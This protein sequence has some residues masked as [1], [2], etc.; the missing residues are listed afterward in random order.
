MKWFENSTL[1]IIHRITQGHPE[2]SYQI[3]IKAYIIAAA[4]KPN[5]F[6]TEVI[7]AATIKFHLQ[8]KLLHCNRNNCKCNYLDCRCKIA[9]AT[10]KTL[11]T[12][13]KIFKSI[14]TI[15]ILLATEVIATAI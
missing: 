14:A 12:V 2:S 11:N 1:Q 13:A 3:N 10:A 7:A 6:T 4:T 5:S 8:Q 15:L 9:N